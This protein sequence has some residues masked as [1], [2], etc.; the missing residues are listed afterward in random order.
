VGMVPSLQSLRAQFSALHPR[1][2]QVGVDDLRHDWY[3]RKTLAGAHAV[4][5]EGRIDRARLLLQQ[6]APSSCRAQL[7]DASL[8]LGH[9]VHRCVLVRALLLTDIMWNCEARLVRA[10]QFGDLRVNV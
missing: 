10:V 4:L 3:R 5:E 8:A 7:W 1:H 6:G 2:R 9:E